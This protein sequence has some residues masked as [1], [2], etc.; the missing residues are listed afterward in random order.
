M[1]Y[2]EELNGVIVNAF[3]VG[4]VVGDKLLRLFQMDVSQLYVELPTKGVPV[5]LPE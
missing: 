5:V 4:G 3:K 1:V 2:E